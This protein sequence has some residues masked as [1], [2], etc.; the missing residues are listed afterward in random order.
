MLCWI[1]KN[2]ERIYSIN[3]DK[4]EESGRVVEGRLIWNFH[5]L[6]KWGSGLEFGLDRFLL[7]TR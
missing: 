4:D 1:C 3:I 6:S 7:L 2:D 5:E